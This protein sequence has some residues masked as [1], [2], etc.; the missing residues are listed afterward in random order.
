MSTMRAQKT[1]EVKR[2]MCSH[3][4]PQGQSE[5]QD[6]PVARMQGQGRTQSPHLWLP[7]PHPKEEKLGNSQAQDP[8]P[9]APG[10]SQ[11]LW[12]QH[13]HR[14]TGHMVPSP[15]PNKGALT[16]HSPSCSIFSC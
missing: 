6:P 2:L 16:H 11:G 15:S 8:S 3:T 9:S 12:D 14:A 1:R 4:A 10:Q 7:L 5:A 13:P